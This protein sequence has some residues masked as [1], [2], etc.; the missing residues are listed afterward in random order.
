MGT[1]RF[2]AEVKHEAVRDVVRY[3]LR[4]K[5]GMRCAFCP[6]QI[7]FSQAAQCDRRRDGATSGV[8]LRCLPFTDNAAGI[9]ATSSDYAK[10]CAA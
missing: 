3:A 8:P 2:T 9:V 5:R 1:R 4:G 6:S 10:P 7:E